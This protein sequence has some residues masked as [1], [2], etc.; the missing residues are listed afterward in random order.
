MRLN[1]PITVIA[2]WSAQRGMPATHEH[3]LSNAILDLPCSWVAGTRPAM[4]VE[5][6]ISSQ[7]TTL[8]GATAR[9][10]SI[11]ADLLMEQIS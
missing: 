5:G 4:T 2:G 9:L 6:L 7:T 1:H 3:G 8:L 10:S 11:A